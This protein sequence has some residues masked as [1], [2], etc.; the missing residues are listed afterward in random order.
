MNEHPSLMP[1][2]RFVL[3]SDDGIILGI[4]FKNPPGHQFDG[5]MTDASSR[6]AANRQAQL[7]KNTPFDGPSLRLAS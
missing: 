7:D 2:S 3:K 4:G 6:H 5:W 1:C